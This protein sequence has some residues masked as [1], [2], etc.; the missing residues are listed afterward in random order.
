MPGV[1]QSRGNRLPVRP[2]AHPGAKREYPSFSAQMC[3]VDGLAAGTAAVFK[4]A[5]RGWHD[6]ARQVGG[7]ERPCAAFAE[8]DRCAGVRSGQTRLSDRERRPGGSVMGRLAARRA[9]LGSVIRPISAGMLAVV[10]EVAQQAPE[11]GDE[12][13]RWGERGEARDG[14]QHAN[15]GVGLTS[16]SLSAADGGDADRTDGFSVSR[17][18]PRAADANLERGGRRDF[19]FCIE[20]YRRLQ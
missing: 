2:L 16:L 5:A 3:D 18:P 10:E 1:V 7:A 8:R 17:G 4:G 13:V 15:T 12:T 11:P 6:D 20:P 19:A 9:M 14:R